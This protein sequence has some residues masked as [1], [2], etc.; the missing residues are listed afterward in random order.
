MRLP[1][2]TSRAIHSASRLAIV[3]LEV[4][5]PRPG[6]GS[7]NMTRSW[8]TTSTSSPLAPGPPSSAWLLG[9]TSIAAR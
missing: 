6:E 4:R 9:L 7:P 2:W 5:W 3:P 1:G 8:S